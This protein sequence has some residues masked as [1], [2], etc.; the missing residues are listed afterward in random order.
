MSKTSIGMLHYGDLFEF[1]G[2][3]YRAGK[4]IENTNGYV[5]CVNTKTHKVTRLYIDTTVLEVKENEN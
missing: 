1:D 3:I 4:L 5:A 2:Q